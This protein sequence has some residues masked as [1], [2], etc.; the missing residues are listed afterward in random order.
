MTG[1]VVLFLQVL[2]SPQE[3][4][5]TL[6]FFY[7]FFIFASSSLPTPT[8]P[9]V[10]P[11]LPHYHSQTWHR[12]VSKANPLSYG[13]PDALSANQSG[14]HHNIHPSSFL[15]PPMLYSPQGFMI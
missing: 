5:T 8:R 9:S 13:P 1:R 10:R 6:N 3:D 12:S 4:I 15:F 11:E 2:L 7:F 14:C